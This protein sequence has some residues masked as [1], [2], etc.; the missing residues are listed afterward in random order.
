MLITLARFNRNIGFSLVYYLLI[1]TNL[2]KP[3]NTIRYVPTNKKNIEVVS[4]I[5]YYTTKMNLFIL[6][7]ILL[8]TT[9]LLCNIP[10]Y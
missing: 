4:L 8:Y 6:M 9:Y 1:S 10:T 2:Y 5:R 3:F 7:C